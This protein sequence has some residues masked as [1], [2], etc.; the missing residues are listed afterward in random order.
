MTSLRF[1]RRRPSLDSSATSVIRAARVSHHA[2]RRRKFYVPRDCG[3]SE[4]FFGRLPAV[5]RVSPGRANVTPRAVPMFEMAR[6]ISRCARV[7]RHW[8]KSFLQLT[9]SK[10]V[11][12]E[13]WRRRRN[14]YRADNGQGNKLTH[15]AAPFDD[16]LLCRTNAD[17]EL[18][19]PF[20]RGDHSLAHWGRVH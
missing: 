10:R 3:P 1:I 17:T 8:T 7:S 5:G 2:R 6:S 9:R 20:F 11:L 16:S 13:N 15:V 19:V 12:G 4:D 14:K 18:T